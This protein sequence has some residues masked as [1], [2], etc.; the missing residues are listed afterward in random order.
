M[1]AV[2]L[3]TYEGQS[4]I[5]IDGEDFHHFANVLRI[6]QNEKL[7]VLNNSGTKYYC[8]IAQIDK[9][10][11]IIKKDYSVKEEIKNKITIAVGITKKDALEDIIR[12]CVE[13]GIP[14]LI[15]LRTQYSQ[16]IELSEERIEKIIKSS[17][18]QSNNAFGIKISFQEFK[19]FD[20]SK[21][22][23]KFIFSLNNSKNEALS[24][25]SN[26]ECLI[27][28]GPE[29]GFSVD[30]EDSL[31]NQFTPIKI[32]SNILRAKTAAAVAF[33]FVSGLSR[34]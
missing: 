12:E 2:F 18:E 15:L 3:K 31:K 9:K 25:N 13:F 22:K 33:G 28:I 30:E 26:D 7:L 10:H 5:K 34:A 21:F 32:N 6:K 1:K 14:E 29:G 20:F 23:N 17:L 16:N 8:D 19:S 24:L 11:L 27:L 4:E